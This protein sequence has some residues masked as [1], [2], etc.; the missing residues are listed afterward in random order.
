M[1]SSLVKSVDV[2]SGICRTP[3]PSAK[4]RCSWLFFGSI[5]GVLLV[6]PESTLWGALAPLDSLVLRV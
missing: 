5:L 4:K 6:L 3:H 1:S 2:D